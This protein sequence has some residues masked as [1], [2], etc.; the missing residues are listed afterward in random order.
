MTS[1]RTQRRVQR[2]LN[3]IDTAEADGNWNL[4]HDLA[5]DVMEIAPGH[6][7]ALAYLHSA[8]RRL[9]RA[10]A[11][12]PKPAFRPVFQVAT[13]PER[14]GVALIQQDT[15]PDQAEDLAHPCSWWRRGRVEWSQSTS[16][17]DYSYHA[18][19]S[20]SRATRPGQGQGVNSIMEPPLFHE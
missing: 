11:I 14:S 16:S 2:L 12:K 15:Q 17:D 13:T 7:E 19:R 8:E 6:A 9:D 10:V 5:S 4:V 20:W 18:R 3:Q 1:D